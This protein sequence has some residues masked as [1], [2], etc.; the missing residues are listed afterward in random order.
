MVKLKI[1]P[2]DAGNPMSWRDAATVAALGALAIWILTFLV[3]ATIGQ[4]RADPAEFAFEAVRAYLIAWAGNFISLTGL[5]LLVKKAT[6]ESG[7]TA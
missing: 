1:N 5:E 6:T 4:L 3:N 7:E 2:F